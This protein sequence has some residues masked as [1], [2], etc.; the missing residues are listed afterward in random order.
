[1]VKLSKSIYIKILIIPLLAQ[2][3]FIQSFFESFTSLQFMYDSIPYVAL[4]S[5]ADNTFYGGIGMLQNAILNKGS[6]QAGLTNSYLYYY[7]KYFNVH[8]ETF[9]QIPSFHLAFSKVFMQDICDGDVKI[10]GACDLPLLSKN[11]TLV[12]FSDIT[13]RTEKSNFQ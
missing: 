6:P 8:Y 7:R 2:A 12:I 5:Q 1:M 11:G 13:V 10:T 3:F 9:G 4:T